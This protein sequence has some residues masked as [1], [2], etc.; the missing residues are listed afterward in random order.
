MAKQTVSQSPVSTVSESPTGQEV[1]TATRMDFPAAMAEV[2]KGKE[3][4]KLEWHNNDYGKLNGGWLMINRN[5]QWHRWIIND[6]DM[7]GT[8]WV[9]RS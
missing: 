2:I 1:T 8:D 3:I 9:I 6:G 7:L 4:T 5:G